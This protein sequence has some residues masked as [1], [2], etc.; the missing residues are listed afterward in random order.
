MRERST[1]K[2][3][4]IQRDRKREEGEEVYQKRTREIAVLY[5]SA[6]AL[7]PATDKESQETSKET[8]EE[9]K[10]EGTDSNSF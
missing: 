5:I 10:D 9:P 1:V 8:H 2:Y 6:N 4:S 7:I 3:C